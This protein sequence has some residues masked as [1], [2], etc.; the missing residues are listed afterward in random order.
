[1]DAHLYELIRDRAAKY[2]DATAVGGQHGI[3][4][5]TLTSRQMLKA[6]DR[7]AGELAALGVREGDRVV[8]W[9]P[10]GWQTPVYYFAIWQLGAIVVPFDRE[11]NP[12]AAAR[13][14]ASVEPRLI[15]VGYDER[16]AWTRE[17]ETIEWWEPG[18]R[19]GPAGPDDTLTSRPASDALPSEELAAIFFTSGTTGDPKGCMITHVNF[20]SQ[21]EALP[22]VATI[23]ASCR[24]ASILPLSHLFEVTV[25]LLYPI[26]CGAAIHDIPS[27]RGPDIVRVMNDQRITHMIAV[28]QVLTLMGQTLETQ[29]RSK[30]PAPAYR[31]LAATADRL[32]LPLR[33]RLFF[34]IHRRIGGCLRFMAAGGAALPPETQRL[35]ERLGVRIAQG[36]GVS[37]CSPVVACGRDDGRTP[38]GS[39]GQPLRD[40]KVRLSP[41]GE[42]LVRGPN[43]MKGY[44]KDP[45][46]TAAAIRDGWLATGD[47]ATRDAD[48][49]LWI[50][51]RARDLIVLPSG[52]NVWPEDLEN[53]LRSQP[54]IKDAAVVAVPTPEGG[55][56]IHAYLLP[57]GSG[58][59][60]TD[61]RGIVAAANGQ[62]AQHQRIATAS[63]WAEADFPRTTT[64]KVRRHLLPAPS[65]A[66]VRVEGA[67][68]AD[69]PV[70][71]AIAGAA[72]LPAVMDAQTLGELG[73]DSL[74]LAELAVAL[75][76]KT[77]RAIADGDLRAEMTVDQVRA[78]LAG[79]P[80]VEARAAGETTSTQQPL[81]PYTIGRALRPLG[82][83]FDVL[84]R[85]AVTRT[86]I[87]GRDHPR[88]LPDRVIF[89][90]THHGFPDMPLIRY[91]VG[92]SPARR[93]AYRLIFAAG[94]GGFPT[95]GLYGYYAILSF[96]LYPLR[97]LSGLDASL[98]DLA[99]VAG[100]G[101]AVVIFPQ[102]THASPEEE[103]ADAPRVRFRPGVAYLA[104]A[105]DAT[106]VPFGTAGSDRLMPPT[107]TGFKGKVIAGI[108]VSIRRGPLAIAFGPPVKL[109]PGETPQAFTARLQGI[110]YG[111]TRE[112]EAALII[113]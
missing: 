11:M 89:A 72:H 41:E 74:G 18:S 112:A 67:L 85:V 34:F 20:C 31:A 53:V 95:A 99:K 45:D 40:V 32:P 37:E 91:A 23:D 64:L 1:M 24:A 14:L 49:N 98:R 63:W 12:G 103:K 38:V 108:P 93:F 7:L 66:A 68:A 105:L 52:M 16:P 94:A 13:I 97:Q 82:V 96:G 9:V 26:A 5:K 80:S 54:A 44:W 75:E 110:C 83:P 78:L 92:Q 43:V 106:V 87:L 88:D 42:I 69:D 19:G 3:G 2:P 4:W 77:G 104:E 113:A 50:S 17:A 33:R 27:R 48:G 107:L 21:V 22:D 102:G 62:L 36:Y 71:Q 39:V 29:L 101:N 111:L 81:W 58:G 86:T 60:S 15:V 51:G 10:N 57:V 28:P 65:E 25:G 76:E 100:R 6:I 84:Y 73:I 90:G 109:E 47:L 30:L 56:Y 79:A 55:A 46:R 61:P 35:W 8:V 70:G 59:L